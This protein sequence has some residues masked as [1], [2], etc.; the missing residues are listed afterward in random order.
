MVIDSYNRIGYVS[1]YICYG[2][3]PARLSLSVRSPYSIKMTEGIELLYGR[4]T[5]NCSK[6]P[7]TYIVG[8]KIWVSPKISV[9]PSRTLS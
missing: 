5:S 4:K 3:I 6:L 8:K 7:S 1:V 2:R 9:L